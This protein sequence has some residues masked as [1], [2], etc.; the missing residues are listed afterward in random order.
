MASSSST[1]SSS[2]LH[3]PQSPPRGPHRSLSHHPSYLSST[4]TS[5]APSTSSP[6]RSVNE[7]R[8]ED[9]SSFHPSTSYRSSSGPRTRSR[10]V[11]SKTKADHLFDQTHHAATIGQQLDRGPGTPDFVVGPKEKS[12]KGKGRVEELIRNGPDGSL[13]PSSSTNSLGEGNNPP[14]LSSRL[15]SFF[16][17]FNAAD[18]VHQNS[19]GQQETKARNSNERFSSESSLHSGAQQESG[20]DATILHRPQGLVIP[21]ARPAVFGE[22]GLNDDSPPL[23]PSSDEDYNNRQRDIRRQWNNTY[24]APGSSADASLHAATQTSSAEART[25][26]M[27][28]GTGGA[29]AAGLGAINSGSEKEH[30]PLLRLSLADVSERLQAG[31]R[32]KSLRQHMP[33]LLMLLT[34]FVFSTMVVFILVTTLPLRMPA[35]SMSQLS[36]TEIR[37]ICLSLREYATSTPRAYHHTLVV[38]CLFFTYLQAFNIPGSIISNV[39]FGALF[40]AW[41]A[42][43]WL[44]IFTA[45]G[46]SGAAVMSALVAPLVLKIPGMQKAVEVMKRALGNSNFGKQATSLSPSNSISMKKRSPA[47]PSS[48]SATPRLRATSPHPSGKAKSHSK[49][50]TGGNLYSILL[51]L[52][53]LPLTPY[54]MMNIACGILNVPLLPFGTTLAIGSVPWNA[55][56]AQLGEILVEVVAAFPVDDDAMSAV[57]NDLA[58]GGVTPPS[59]QH[60]MGEQFDAGGFEVVPKPGSIGSDGM[61]NVIASEKAK[62]SSAAQ[63]AGGGVKILLAK[64]W[65][66]EMILKLVGLSLLSIT[67]VLLG[68]WWKARQARQAAAASRARKARIA[69]ERERDAAEA[70]KDGGLPVNSTPT[71]VPVATGANPAAAVLNWSDGENDDEES[72]FGGSYRQYDSESDYEDEDEEGS[73]YEYDED[74]EGDETI[75]A[76]KTKLGFAAMAESTPA[77]IANLTRS[78]SRNSWNSNWFKAATAGLGQSGVSKSSS[79]MSFGSNSDEPSQPGWPSYEDSPRNNQPPVTTPQLELAHNP[80]ESAASRTSTDSRAQTLPHSRSSKHLSSP[81]RGSFFDPHSSPPKRQESIDFSVHPAVSSSASTGGHLGDH[82]GGGHSRQGSAATSVGS[83]KREPKRLHATLNVG[84]VT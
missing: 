22:F 29:L 54:G 31:L 65:T 4:H 23:T 19:S 20:H 14:R 48:R 1:P 7:I 58:M 79:P 3:L 81:S 51:L 76:R 69:A 47:S 40:G 55:V 83:E 45:V 24:N 26:S 6:P 16:T 73:S 34:F 84:G 56:T 66:R 15:R 5:M 68:K 39:V 78:A 12:A 74:E 61:R 63:K 71:N 41:R 37:E 17:S 27:S 43:F 9:P 82:F 33:T 64:I 57:A 44:S 62:L 21:S 52:R 59:M 38:L 67:P 30:R 60:S 42:T 49:K 35:H 77:F 50:P 8:P 18:D 80:F 46:G 25:A 10:S 32:S 36:L 70:W 13:R 75:G 72:S 28:L 11:G 2:R 53:L